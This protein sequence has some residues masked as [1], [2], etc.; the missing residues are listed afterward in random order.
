MIYLFVISA[1][2]ILA[3]LLRLERRMNNVDTVIAQLQADDVA[4]KAKID[5]LVTKVADLTAQLAAGTPVTQAQLD[6]LN[7]IHVDLSALGTP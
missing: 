1:L 3:A 5:G 4:V 6:A 2:A 7:A